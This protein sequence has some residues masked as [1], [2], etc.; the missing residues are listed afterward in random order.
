VKILAERLTKVHEERCKKILEELESCLNF[1][2]KYGIDIDKPL[3]E[4][5]D[6]W[7]AK[8]L[9]EP[10]LIELFKKYLEFQALKQDL[11]SC[12]SRLYRVKRIVGRE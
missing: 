11:R 1:F 5:R 6:I 8:A 3:G 7:R 12:S 2:R 9:P 4:I 10:E